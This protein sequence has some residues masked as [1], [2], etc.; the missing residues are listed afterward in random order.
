MTRVPPSAM[1]FA[2]LRT[3]EK[4]LGAYGEDLDLSHM[5]KGVNVRIKVHKADE[6]HRLVYAWALV[7]EEGGKP[8]VDWQGDVIVTS[9][10]V[11]TAHGFIRSERMA[12][13][14]HEGSH[15]GDIVESMVFTSELQKALGIDLGKVGWLVVIK[16]ADD[17]AWQAVKDGT[18]KSLS[19][20][21]KA[22]REAI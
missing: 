17:A 9:E 22:R 8:V 6:E 4:L 18:Y 11:K 15:V 1:T 7:I 2:D 16:V 5:T 13:A 21:G 20:G 19:I 14:M 10:L 3:V 12:K